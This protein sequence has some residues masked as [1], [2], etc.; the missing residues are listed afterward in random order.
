[1]GNDDDDDF[2]VLEAAPVGDE[3]VACSICWPK[4]S[5]R[6]SVSVSPASTSPDPTDA[7][8][9]SVAGDDDA[10]KVLLG[11]VYGAEVW[12][13]LLSVSEPWGLLRFADHRNEA[14]NVDL[15]SWVPDTA[16]IDA[17]DAWHPE[18]ALYAPLTASDGSRLG[19]C[20]WTCPLTDDAQAR[21]RARR[22]KPSRSPP[23]SRSS[24]RRCEDGP[25]TPSVATGTWPPMIP[26]QV[27]ATAR[28]SSSGSNTP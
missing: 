24:T 3:L 26:S 4:R 22:W 23:H 20:R 12:D 17:E 27:S 28:C 7:E 10:R 15:L 11:T 21:P 19:I 5:S 1:M 13:E 14:A 16:P 2:E 25:R 6:R 8:V 18:D 9:V